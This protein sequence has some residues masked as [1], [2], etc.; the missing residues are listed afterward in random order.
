MAID[1]TRPPT[2]PVRRTDSPV[3][4]DERRTRMRD[5]GFGRVFT[6]HM[7]SARWSEDRGW[8]DT[9]VVPYGP[10]AVDP[11][12]S[13]L[14]YGQVVFEGLKAFRQP[15]GSAALFRP[16]FHARRLRRSARRLAIP[17]PPELLL[18]AA[19][20]AVVR[21][22]L[23]WLPQ[24][25]GHSLYLRPLLFASE[26]ALGLRP[27]REYQLLVIA[28]V[29]SP[30]LGD[31][32]LAVWLD[33]EYARAAPGGTGEAKSAGNYA[34]AMPAQAR[35]L[36]EGCQQVV[37]VDAIDRRW[38]EEMGAMNLFF[39]RAGGT[40]TRLSTPPLSGTILAGATRDTLLTLGREAGLAVAEER[41]SIDQWRTGC[42]DGSITEVF[43]CGTATAVAPI[44]A[45]R[46][47]TDG[48]TVGDGALGPVTRGLRERLFAAQYG[49]VPDVQGW[50][51]P[52]PVPVRDGL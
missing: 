18:I 37:W 48:W 24:E 21:E 1:Q 49:Q 23:G 45:V 25:P 33:H 31:A 22:D 28:F 29:C 27:A 8:H 38:V 20:E 39:V 6:D 19:L 12:M 32:P 51:H 10:V 2:F 40:G 30:M 5:P 4:P 35:A 17:E 43:A 16:D 14:H 41:L 7:A 11:A 44:G 47:R 52:V 13:G 46:T 34:A 50:L 3:P 26:A 9:R 15:D 42:A 36:A